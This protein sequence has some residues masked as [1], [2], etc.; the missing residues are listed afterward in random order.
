MMLKRLET[1]R[2]LLASRMAIPEIAPAI[3]FS[4][5]TLYR[6]FSAPAQEAIN[7]EGADA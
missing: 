4:V 5:S 6:H 2:Q 1:A 7:A 3:G